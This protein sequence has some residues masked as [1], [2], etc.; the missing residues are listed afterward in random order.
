MIVNKEAKPGIVQFVRYACVGVMNTLVTLCVIFLCKSLLGIN[1]LV[2]NAI[3][4]I[5]G[6]INSFLWNKNWVFCS[7]GSYTPEAIRFVVGFI[8]CYGIQFLVVWLLNY[9]T[10][11]R[12]Y[13]ID[14][15][16]FTLSGYG[17]ATLIGNVVYTGSNFM[18]NKLVTFKT[19]L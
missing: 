6:V 9:K 4:Y 2:S 12:G 11:L 13:E 1:P 10:A 14:I 5:A 3:G 17:L 19:H 7:A 16:S 18:F 8:V 15:Y